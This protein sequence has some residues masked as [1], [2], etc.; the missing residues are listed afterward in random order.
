MNVA[1]GMAP[2]TSPLLVLFDSLWRSGHTSCIL[3]PAVMKYNARANSSRQQLAVDAIWSDEYIAQVLTD[4]GLS[5]QKSDL[6]DTLDGLFREFG[7]P[8]TLREVGVE[9]EENLQILAERSL[10]DI[11]CVSNPVPLTTEAQVLEILRMVE[12]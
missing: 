9:G 8:R 7:M 3:M 5:A 2:R 4:R 6:G 1:H 11:W 10:A 12:R